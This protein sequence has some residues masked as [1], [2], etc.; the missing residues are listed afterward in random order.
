MRLIK[1]P[2]IINSPS[3]ISIIVL[4]ATPPRSNKDVQFQKMDVKKKNN[5]LN[6]KAQ[7]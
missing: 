7:V 6:S 2:S 4:P 3:A 1:K 5:L